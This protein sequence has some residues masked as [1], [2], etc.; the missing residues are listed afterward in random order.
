MQKNLVSDGREPFPF[1][2]FLIYVLFYAGQAMYNV[3]L[4]LFLNQNGF[5][6]TQLGL[7]SSV[8][9]VV[10]VL[11]QPLWGVLSDKSKSKNQIVGMLLLISAIVGLAFYASKT[12]LWLSLC[13]LL[14]NVFFNPAVTL[15]DNYTLEMLEGGRWDFGQLRLG[16]T[17]GYAACAALIGYV[18]GGSIDIINAFTD[19]ICAVVLGFVVETDYEH[20]FWM[21][22]IFFIITG[23][24]YFTLPR[25]SG[26]REKKQKVKYSLLLKDR[27]L[28]CMFVFNIVYTLGTAFFYQFYSIH[29]SNEL[30]ASSV[31]VGLL[32]TFG[33]LSEIPF[34]WFAGR[35][36]KRFGTKALMLFAGASAA[37]RWLLLSML[38]NTS[39]ILV[40]NMLSGCGFVGFSYSLIRYI[41]DNVPK[42]M[43]ATAQSLN[44]ILG[45]FFSRIIFTPINGILAD[46]FSISTVL[47]GNGLLMVAAVLLFAFTFSKAEAYQK[48]HPVLEE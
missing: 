6:N 35:L 4:N 40:V 26:H 30:G 3:Y 48:A 22:G 32:S 24:L 2:M 1:K 28:V 25:V 21:M 9:T 42:S 46:H 23:V 7:L 47:L 8:S 36:Q 31:M 18:V 27:R 13:V 11:V 12:A 33:A 10:L 29:Y 38:T 41:N 39:V 34:F 44:G 19:A 16:G 43:R 17:L 45:T 5:S 15:Q 14:F 37:A 20:I